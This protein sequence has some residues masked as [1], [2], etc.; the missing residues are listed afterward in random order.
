MRQ[1]ML[2]II[3]VLFAMM[4]LVQLG[5]LFNE[6]FLDSTVKKATVYREIIT[7]ESQEA[8]NPDQS[9]YICDLDL[10]LDFTKLSKTDVIYYMLLHPSNQENKI[11]HP[12]VYPDVIK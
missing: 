7:D 6:Y 12:S 4:H 2:K 8:S 5:D 10:N 1:N 3:M 9:Y 11:I